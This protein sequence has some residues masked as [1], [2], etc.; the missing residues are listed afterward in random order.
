M[1][2][3]ALML[4]PPP[5]VAAQ[6]EPKP[7]ARELWEAYPL[8]RESGS[9]RA[10]ADEGEAAPPPAQAPQP[11]AGPTG[12]GTRPAPERPA[13]GGASSPLLLGV[14]AVAA[15]VLAA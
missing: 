11:T 10:P 7:S 14:G 5:G 1:A 9:G 6:G 13:D 8:E 2:C 3:V 15:V 12:S 4:A